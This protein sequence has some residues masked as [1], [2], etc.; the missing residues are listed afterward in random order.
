L[1]GTLHSRTGKVSYVDGNSK[2]SVLFIS[3]LKHL[4]ASY[5]RA[6]MI[7]LRVDNYI[8]HPQEP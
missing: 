8:N 7:K 3:L 1:A 6:K 5:C 2:S 4:K